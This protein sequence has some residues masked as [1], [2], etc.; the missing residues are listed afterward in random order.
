MQCKS[1]HEHISESD[2]LLLKQQYSEEAINYLYETAFGEEHGGG[3]SNFLS[4]WKNDVWIRW[5]GD[6]WP[7]D[8]LYVL[9]TVNQLNNLDLPIKLHITKD[10]SVT[11]L[12]I[13]FGK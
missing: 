7:C 10:T 5:E 12:P 6:L 4:K 3:P 11:N 13:Y 8:S 1:K 2:L 9:Q